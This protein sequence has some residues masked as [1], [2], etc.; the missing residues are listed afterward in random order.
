MVRTLARHSVCL[1]TEQ[2]DSG[3][4]YDD[5]QPSQSYYDI[6]ERVGCLNDSVTQNSTVFKCLEN[7]DSVTL[8]K[9]NSYTNLAAKYGQW[10]FLPVTD[11]TFLTSRPSQQLLQ[12]RVNGER[13]VVGNNANE[14]TYFV[15]QNI[16]TESQ[17]RDF[18]TSNYPLL[19]AQNI[20][21]VMNLYW[22]SANISVKYDSNGL[23]PPFATSISNFAAGWQ[24]AANNLYAETTFVCPAYWLGQAYSSGKGKKGWRYQFSVPNAFHGSDLAP[25]MSSPTQQGTKEDVAFR[26]AFQ[27]IWGNFIVSGDPTLGV[28][29][30]DA[31]G[32]LISAAGSS[33]WLSIGDTSPLLNLN[34]T[35]TAPFQ[36]QFSVVDGNAWEGGRGER[37][38]LWAALGPFALD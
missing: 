12:G 22:V 31:G 21:A 10:A 33:S 8:Q 6:A 14:G 26:T 11:G 25:L 5:F 3:R 24:Q 18:V 30:T 29:V 7:I 1:T 37:C 15:Q 9:A 16:A 27:R 28:N 38:A 34:V 19:S 4:D 17:F 32:D 13:I 23:T 35:N 36:A 2:A 20:T